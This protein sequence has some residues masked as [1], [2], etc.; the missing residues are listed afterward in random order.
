[1]MAAAAPEAPLKPA[2]RIALGRRAGLVSGLLG[3]LCVLAELCFLL[4]MIGRG[5]AAPMVLQHLV[6]RRRGRGEETEE[7]GPAPVDH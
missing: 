2:L 7:A 6:A 5:L 3:M 1:M 4:P